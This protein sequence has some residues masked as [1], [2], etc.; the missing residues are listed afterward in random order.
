MTCLI[1]CNGMTNA[2]QIKKLLERHLTKAFTCRLPR[3]LAEGG[4][5]YAVKVKEEQL[6]RALEIIRDNGLKYRR[7]FHFEDNTCKEVII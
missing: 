4:C 7:V 5:A 3:D 6:T 1:E 2:Q